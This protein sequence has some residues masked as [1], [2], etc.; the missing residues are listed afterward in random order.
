M[1]ASKLDNAPQTI[2]APKIE[3]EKEPRE[4]A[5]TVAQGDSLLKIA[6]R[7]N[8]TVAQPRRPT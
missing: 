2:A 6:N 7:F 4:V 3:I 1:A 5:Y 8:T